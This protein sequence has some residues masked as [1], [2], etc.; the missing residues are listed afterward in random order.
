MT[1]APA[2]SNPVPAQ[3]VN[4]P[5]PAPVAAPAV[6]IANAAV[7]NRAGRLIVIPAADDRNIRQA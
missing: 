2:Q 6:N 3:A 5:N 1:A 7:L 4:R